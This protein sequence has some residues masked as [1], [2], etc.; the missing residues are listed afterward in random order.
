VVPFVIA[1]VLPT[2][3]ARHPRV[4]VEQRFVDIVAEGY[5]AAFARKAPARRDSAALPPGCVIA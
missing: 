5:D 3:R 1:P 4:E 2:L